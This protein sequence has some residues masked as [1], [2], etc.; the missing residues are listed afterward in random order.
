MIEEFYEERVRMV[1]QQIKNRGITDKKILEAFK[2]VPRH[3]FVPVEYRDLA[4]SDRPLPIGNDQTISQ[5]YIIAAML[6]KLNLNP[7]SKILEVGSGC[8]YVL[9]ILSQIVEQVYG[10]ERQSSLVKRSRS[11]MTRLG[12]DNV[13]I[14]YGD[15]KSGWAEQ[16]P[17]AGIVVSAATSEPPEQL[18]EQLNENGRMMIPLGN[19]FSQRLIL[20]HKKETGQIET[21]EFEPVRFVPLVDGKS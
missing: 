9:A 15:G 19:S 13:E 18:L 3:E 20:Y 17:F 14:R 1:D 21:Q 16:S 6:T 10:I 4:Y 7:D 12:Y 11:T 2:S 8:G 5:P